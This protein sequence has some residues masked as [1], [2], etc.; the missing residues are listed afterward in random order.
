MR[1]R[2]TTAIDVTAMTS[3]GH[4]TSSVTSPTDSAVLPGHF[5]IIIIIFIFRFFLR[6][7]IYYYLLTSSKLQLIN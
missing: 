6:F 2:E 7:T 1:A 4:V 5:P 3:S